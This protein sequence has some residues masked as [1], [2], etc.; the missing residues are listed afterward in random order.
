MTPHST[1]PPRRDPEDFDA[2]SRR[3]TD[4]ILDGIEQTLDDLAR[5]AALRAALQR[6][7]EQALEAEARVLRCRHA[8]CRR[9]K[10]C[11]R[12]PCAVPAGPTQQGCE[13]RAGHRR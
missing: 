2:R 11:R 7:G 10:Q 13:R 5:P 4:R 12:R 3:I 6:A 1:E 9:V 8:L